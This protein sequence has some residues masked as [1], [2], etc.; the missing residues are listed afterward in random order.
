MRH[1]LQ[2]RHLSSKIQGVYVTRKSRIS[3]RLF[4]NFTINGQPL[5]Q[6][7][8][9]QRKKMKTRRISIFIFNIVDMDFGKTS[10]ERRYHFG[11]KICTLDHCYQNA[12]M[13]PFLF[14][15]NT[16]TVVH[17][18]VLFPCLKM[19]HIYKCPAFIVT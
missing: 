5:Q 15:L 19:Q 3:Y 12:L 18:L 9:C 2:L 10:N 8:Y 16:K 1:A 13:W 11:E 14:I 4:R 17:G 7:F 6:P